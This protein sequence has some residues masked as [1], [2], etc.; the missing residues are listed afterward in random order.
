MYSVTG[1]W[2]PGYSIRASKWVSRQSFV[3][4]SAF[5]RLSVGFRS[6][7]APAAFLSAWRRLA[8][9]IGK[10]RRAVDY[11]REVDIVD[12]SRHRQ[13]EID[14]I[15]GRPELSSMLIRA[16]FDACDSTWNEG[17]SECRLSGFTVCSSC[18]EGCALTERWEVEDDFAEIAGDTSI[19]FGDGLRQSAGRQL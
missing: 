7:F 13:R 16:D 18:Y 2:M 15:D 14:C 4:V 5:G 8:G 1:F 9:L 3:P 11:E 17:G 12:V 6:P 10:L 19:W